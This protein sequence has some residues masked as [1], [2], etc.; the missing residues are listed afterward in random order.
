MGKRIK[1][2]DLIVEAGETNGGGQSSGKLE[3]VKTSIKQE[4]AA[5]RGFDLDK[6]IPNFEQNYKI[7]KAAASRG[8]TKRK[9]MPV[10]TDDD[11]KH[12]QYR[13]SKGYIDI[14]APHAK[15][16]DRTNPF[17]QGLAGGQAKKWL[18]S[19]LPDSDGAELG[20]DAVKVK[21]GKVIISKLKPIQKQI[22]VDKSLGGTIDF[23]VKGSLKFI[24]GKS[25]FIISADNYIIDGHHRYLSGML[26]NPKGA[27]NAL[28]IDLPI[29]T[30]LPLTLAYGDAIGNT[31]N[32]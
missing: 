21:K 10:I 30:L 27:V 23:G 3:L 29:K 8:S 9:D 19:G 7:A 5:K 12:L 28:I 6:E 24:F 14:N 26:L 32:A 1:L 13:L 31:R 15:E 11:V 17:P 22:Y 20:D 25:Y 2:V 4:Y 16:W 18:K